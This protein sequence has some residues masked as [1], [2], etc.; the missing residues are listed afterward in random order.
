MKVYI[1]AAS[2]EIDRAE[3]FFKLLTS[4]GIE[5]TSSWIANV[6]SVG[7]GNPVAAT[8]EDRKRWALD[9][10]LAIE[11]SAVVW[12]LAPSTGVFSHG[13]Y[14]ELGYAVARAR[15]SVATA[16]VNSTSVRPK[17][18]ASGGDHR[19]VFLALADELYKTDT[20]ALEDLYKMRTKEE[21][22][23]RFPWP[24]RTEYE[25]YALI[26]DQIRG[27]E[28][29]RR[30]WL[31]T[32]CAGKCKQPYRIDSMSPVYLEIRAALDRG[33]RSIIHCYHRGY[34]GFAKPA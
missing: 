27:Q 29:I 6:R 5:C 12:I 10:L 1:A 9:N 18:I 17:I 31:E 4:Q 21:Q 26:E 2:S 19:W 25:H 30:S 14:F 33:D 20:N 34:D 11:A 28:T 7:E 22:E 23:A 15:S 13:A 16:W 8:F 24:R 3:F 32:P